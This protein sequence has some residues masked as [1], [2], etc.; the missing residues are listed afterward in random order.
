MPFH[1]TRCHKLIVQITMKCDPWWRNHNLVVNMC[2][3]FKFAKVA[4]NSS[5]NVSNLLNKNEWHFNKIM[6]RTR[7]IVPRNKVPMNPTWFEQ[8]K[9]YWRWIWITKHTWLRKFQ[10]F[11]HVPSNLLIKLIC[12]SFDWGCVVET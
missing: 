8:F 7:N 1:P 11:E 10:N 3:L 9:Y 5:R 6:N 4:L 12:G 2:S